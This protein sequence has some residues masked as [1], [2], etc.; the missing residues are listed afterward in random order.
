[1]TKKC[2]DQHGYDPERAAARSLFDLPISAR[3]KRLIFGTR[4]I[5]GIDRLSDKGKSVKMSDIPII[6]LV[7]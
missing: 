1:M 6:G 2:D 7:G 5:D 3:R 4:Q